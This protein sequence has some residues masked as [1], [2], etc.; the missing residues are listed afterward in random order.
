MKASNISKR[1]FYIK[2]VVFKGN[3]S[4]QKT[5]DRMNGLINDVIYKHQ[6]VLTEFL[7]P[8]ERD[9]LKKLAGNEVCLQSFG[10]Y[11]NAEKKRVVI[12]EDWAT[13]SPLS[14]QISLFEIEYPQKFVSL[15]HSDVL[16]S[17][18][19]AGIETS[20]FGDIITDGNGRWQFFGKS[21]LTDFFQYEI[22]HI[23]HTKVKLRPISSE[24]ILAVED[25]SKH[26]TVIASS[27]RLDAVLA[28][29]AKQSRSQIKDN[30]KN[31]LVKLNW[32][33]IKDFNIIIEEDNVLSLR[34]FGRCKIMGISTTKK[35][36][37]KVVY[38][39]WQTKRKKRRS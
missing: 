19:N 27:L 24:K 9:I 6:K 7:D 31:N 16:G 21:E 36:N 26:L 14:Y 3:L 39:L 23:G 8:G 13:G 25:E 4:D 35:G 30:I 37:Y 32:H 2:N 34:H 10:G 5:V 28:A 29:I 38:K 12:T 1:S 15:T 22:T 33:T 17:I 11:L 18:A 20:T